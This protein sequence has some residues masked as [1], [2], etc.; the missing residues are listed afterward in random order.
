MPDIQTANATVHLIDAVMVPPSATAG[1]IP[2][3][4]AGR[5]SGGRVNGDP[6]TGAS[7]SAAQSR[8]NGG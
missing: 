6:A 3:R 1:L 2:G 4:P 5:Q 8:L 7:R